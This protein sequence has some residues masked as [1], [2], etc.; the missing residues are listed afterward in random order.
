[1]CSIFSIQNWVLLIIVVVVV[2]A[3]ASAASA[4]VIFAGALNIGERL[5]SFHEIMSITAGE[6]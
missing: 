4:D 3:D 2:V 6:M 1:M 5:L